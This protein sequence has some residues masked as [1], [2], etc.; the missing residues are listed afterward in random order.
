[1]L[2]PGQELNLSGEAAC[3][4]GC[5]QAQTDDPGQRGTVKVTATIC[6]RVQVSP[7]LEPQRQKSVVTTTVT[8]PPVHRAGG[9][10]NHYRVVDFKTQQGRY[11]RQG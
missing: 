11:P 10:K 4:H 6:T 3:N 5:Y 9:H 8:S 7:L 1:M 2:K